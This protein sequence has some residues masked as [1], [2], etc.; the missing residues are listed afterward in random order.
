MTPIA[1][2]LF[3]HEHNRRTVVVHVGAIDFGKP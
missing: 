3:T 2:P 1:F